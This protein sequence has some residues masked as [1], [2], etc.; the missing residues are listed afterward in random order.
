MTRT[1]R[2]HT[3]S[4]TLIRTLDAAENTPDAVALRERGYELL[5]L[6]PGAT[7]VDVGCGTGRAVAELEARGARALG[8]DLDPVMLTAARDRFPGIDVRAA[9]A[10]GLPLADGEARGYRADK[11]LHIL[12]DPA[13]AL[14]E[15]RRVL[16]PAGRIVL[17]GQDWDTVVVD[18]GSGELT[19]RIIAARADTIPHPRIA[20]AYRNLLLDSGFT[21]VTVEVH[22]AIRTD[23]AT[24]LLLAA[25][26]TAARNTGAITAAEATQWIA[27]QDRR[28]TSGRLMLAIPMFLAAGT[29]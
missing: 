14:A 27:E 28:A 12:S 19:R 1:H 4:A 22:T 10:D 6:E 13:A 15:A 5:R 24:R 18:S 25:Q 20:R 26:A 23:P 21:D 9:D 2:D 17:V 7:V 8:V 3:D 11:V 29:R 16:A